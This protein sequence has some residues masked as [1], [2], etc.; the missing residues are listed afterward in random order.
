MKKVIIIFG[1][2]FLAVNLSSCT[3]ER[4]TV[5]SCD[6]NINEF[7]KSNVRQF[8]DIPYDTLVSYDIASHEDMTFDKSLNCWFAGASIVIP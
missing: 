7:V 5:Y 6:E 2:I 8:S 4:E 1:I 3:K